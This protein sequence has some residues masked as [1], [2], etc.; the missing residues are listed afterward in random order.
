MSDKPNPVSLST[1]FAADDPAILWFNAEAERRGVSK[2][3]MIKILIEEAMEGP[4]APTDGH[5]APD[6]TN[7]STGPAHSQRCEYCSGKGQV[8]IMV[9]GKTEWWPCAKCGSLGSY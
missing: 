7:T 6:A 8:P 2:R 5:Q 3:A 1:Q 9:E 4:T